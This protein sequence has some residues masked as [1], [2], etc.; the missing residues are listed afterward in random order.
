M[1]KEQ[2]KRRPWGGDAQ[3]SMA[4]RGGWG[5]AMIEAF[6]ADGDALGNCRGL[7][8]AALPSQVENNW[9]TFRACRDVFSPQVYGN[10]PPGR[11]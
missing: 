8:L 4:I 7:G 11:I 5:A 10:W 2:H 1:S 3:N 6:A 9:K